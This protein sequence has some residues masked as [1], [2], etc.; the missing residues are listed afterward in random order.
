[1]YFTFCVIQQN[2]MTAVM[3]HFHQATP[4]KFKHAA[5]GSQC[6]SICITALIASKLKSANDWNSDFVD[7]ILLAGDGLHLNIL[8]KKGWPFLRADSRLGIDELPE[9]I[10]ISIGQSNVLASVGVRDEAEFALSLYIDTFITSALM[11]KSNQSF[12]LRI[13]D[14]YIAIICR[15]YQ[16]YS[17]FDPHTRNSHGDIDG[18][19]SAALLH[20]ANSVALMNYLTRLAAGRNEQIDLY[21][22]YIQVISADLQN[23]KQESSIQIELESI[24]ESETHLRKFNCNIMNVFD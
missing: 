19:G 2:N 16:E 8:Q 13:S 9:K 1:M 4:E 3:G 20:F 21:P 23:L 15:N 6:S 11:R 12:V 24:Q 5:T 10:E 17:I 18:E 7:A 22:V 14:S